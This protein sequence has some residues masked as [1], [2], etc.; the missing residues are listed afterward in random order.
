MMTFFLEF[1]RH[2]KIDKSLNDT[3]IALI[4]KKRNVV[5]IKYFH[6]ISLVKIVYKLLAKVLT[7]RL[8]MVLENLISKL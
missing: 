5:N 2:C 8:K 7:N 6:P 1:Y 3:F 4:P